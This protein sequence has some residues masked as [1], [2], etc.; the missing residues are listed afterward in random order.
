VLAQADISGV[1]AV[2]VGLL[3]LLSLFALPLLGAIP[4][5]A[6]AP[7][8]IVV[9]SL[10]VSNISDIDWK[11]PATSIPA[12][13]TLVMIPLT[14]SIA[15][16]LAFGFIAYSLIKLAQGEWRRVHWLVYVLTLLFSSRASSIWVD[17]LRSANNRMQANR[18]RLQIL[19]AL[20]ALTPARARSGPA[21]RRCSGSLSR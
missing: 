3:F 10:M 14:F 18:F 12:F 4:T 8:L 6:T 13:L 9:G 5:A 20:S 11:S 21:S 1:T 16:G 15:N 17:S 2:I 7:V 19:T